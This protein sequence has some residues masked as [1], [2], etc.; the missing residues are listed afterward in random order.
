MESL[1]EIMDNGWQDAVIGF[2]HAQFMD[3]VNGFLEAN[4]N[5][6]SLLD[7]LV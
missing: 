1:K 4:I 3:K 5:L 7:L 6:K 2:I